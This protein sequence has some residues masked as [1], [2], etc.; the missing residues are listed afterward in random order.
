[1]DR[2]AHGDRVAAI[3]ARFGLLGSGHARR[4]HVLVEDSGI[5]TAY[6]PT[7]TEREFR[8]AVNAAARQLGYAEPYPEAA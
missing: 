2:A 7:I 1:M 5:L 4:R 3:N 8:E 6:R